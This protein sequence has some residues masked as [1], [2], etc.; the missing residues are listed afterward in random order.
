MKIDNVITGYPNGDILH[1]AGRMILLV[2]RS[3]I[4]RSSYANN[5]GTSLS[6]SAYTEVVVRGGGRPS[7]GYSVEG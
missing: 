6:A 3:R 7:V 4:R 2:R 5:D 1:V